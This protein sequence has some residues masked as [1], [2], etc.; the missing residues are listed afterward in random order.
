MPYETGQALMGTIRHYSHIQA[1]YKPL[2]ANYVIASLYYNWGKTGA[3]LGKNTQYVRYECRSIPT[4]HTIPPQIDAVGK[5]YTRILYYF[6]VLYELWNCDIRSIWGSMETPY[7]KLSIE[8]S[9]PTPLWA[10]A[11]SPVP[12]CCD[13]R[14]RQWGQGP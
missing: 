13:V 8:L 4:V 6:T 11:T 9:Y 3:G 10:D 1:T 5:Y 7:V 2:P 14:D 12:C